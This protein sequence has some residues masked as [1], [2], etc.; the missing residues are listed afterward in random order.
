M[1]DEELGPEY[2][3]TRGVPSSKRGYD[4]RVIDALL[5]EARDHW[6]QLQ[7]K[8]EALR[9]SVEE[10]G[11][12]EFLGREL[13]QVGAEVGEVLTAA[14]RAADG[15]RARTASESERIEREATEAAT[16]AV[17]EAE[18]Q[19]FELRRSAWETGMDLLDS[20]LLKVERIIKAGN[21]DGL[22]I[23]AQAEKDAHRHIAGAE[24][25]AS[26]LM[27]QARYEADRQLNQAREV[28]QQII[29][30]AATP[31]YPEVR[32][33]SSSLPEVE[34]RRDEL[35]EEIERLRLERNIDSVKVFNDGVPEDRHV[36]ARDAAFE[37][38]GIDLSDVLA[39]EVQ[40]MREPETIKVRVDPPAEAFGT[41]DDVGTLFEALRVTGEVET[42]V[43][44]DPLPT[45]PLELRERLLV[46]IVD[47]GTREVK[48]RIVDM[49]N[50]A[51]DGLRGAGWTP[52]PPDVGRELSVVLEPLVHRAGSAGAQAAGPLAGI[53][54]SLSEPGERAGQLTM[55]MAAA[56]SGQLAAALEDAGGPE[57]SAEAIGRVFRTW[58]NQDAERWVRSV[59]A[60]AY[61]DSLLAALRSSGVESVTA[62]WSGNPCDQCAAPDGL[63]WRPGRLPPNDLRV[64]PANLGCTCTVVPGG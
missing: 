26:D 22:L 17:E 49:Q 25:E 3:T 41:A 1:A 6:Q 48:R 61:H 8:Y 11:G 46:P 9:S 60:A 13:S 4:K 43:V 52:H 20:A 45:D 21:D 5:G 30:R 59:G 55:S 15:M 63:S 34:A 19:A 58:R 53:Y 62:L 51:L 18:A 33:A 24:R 42:V 35:L 14:Q 10:S 39:A 2:L 37:P 56:L 27:R 44:E 28:A 64:P 54:G 12:L 47:G 7:D 38:D 57:Q 50:V 36:S 23:R 29:D 31:Q 32:E 16:S 40:G